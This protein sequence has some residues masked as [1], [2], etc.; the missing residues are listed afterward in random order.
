MV[1]SSGKPMLEKSSFFFV[2]LELDQSENI[3]HYKENRR[4]DDEQFLVQECCPIN[5]KNNSHSLNQL[6]KWNFLSFQQSKFFYNFFFKKKIYYR[7]NYYHGTIHFFYRKYSR[8]YC[9]TST[10]PF[11]CLQWNVFLFFIDFLVKIFSISNF[12]PN[13]LKKTF[14]ILC[15]WTAFRRALI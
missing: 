11:T 3:F 10:N 7:R 9:K 6:F 14:S 13:S 5:N 4:P 15:R 12:S 2:I 8:S 1:K